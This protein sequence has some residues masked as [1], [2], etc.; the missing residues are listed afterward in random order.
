MEFHKFIFT[1][2]F[3]P[4]AAKAIL[5]TA[6]ATIIGNLMKKNDVPI[7]EE[8]RIRL[9]ND[10]KAYKKLYYKF[11]VNPTNAKKYL[12]NDTEENLSSF[13]NDEYIGN[14]LLYDT[15]STELQQLLWNFINNATEDNFNS[16][17]EQIGYE[18]RELCIKLGH[19]IL[20]ELGAKRKYTPS[21]KFL[22][23][24]NLSMLFAIFSA[25]FINIKIIGTTCLLICLI[26]GF[27]AFYQYFRFLKK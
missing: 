26:L 16:I 9:E 20:T 23:F 7:T 19:G 13:C 14:K 24:G 21:E 3:S 18:Y 10:R 11:Y 5:G 12:F 2:I 25:I 27:I 4:E 1:Y 17:Q 8:N 22:L 15:L 6:S